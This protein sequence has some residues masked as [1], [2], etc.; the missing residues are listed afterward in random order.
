[1]LYKVYKSFMIHKYTKK[2]LKNYYNAKTENKT[3]EI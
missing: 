1:M 2:L 3:N